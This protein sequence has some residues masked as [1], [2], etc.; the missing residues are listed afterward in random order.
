MKFGFFGLFW[1]HNFYVDLGD[2]KMI[3]AV[4]WALADF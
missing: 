4:F 3:L 2:L 1:P